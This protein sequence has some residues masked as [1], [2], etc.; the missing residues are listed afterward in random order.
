ML[1]VKGSRPWGVLGAGTRSRLRGWP[2]GLAQQLGEDLTRLL[3]PRMSDPCQ[4][5]RVLAL[6]DDHESE[7]PRRI[8]V[9]VL[10]R[11]FVEQLELGV[12]IAGLWI[13]SV[14]GS[15]LIAVG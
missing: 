10:E 11:A 2:V 14:R 15:L 9:V 5:T 6:D 7:G 4:T 12:K 13:G 1:I 8:A 3:S